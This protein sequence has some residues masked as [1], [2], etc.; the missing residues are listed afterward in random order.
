MSQCKIQVSYRSML[1][2]CDPFRLRHRAVYVGNATR[3]VAVKY[4]RD[5]NEFFTITVRINP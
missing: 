3:I 5:T 2:S 1:Q 4:E